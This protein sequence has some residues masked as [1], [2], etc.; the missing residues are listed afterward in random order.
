LRLSF[1]L[2]TEVRPDEFGLRS[3]PHFFSQAEYEAR[4]ENISA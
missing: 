3:Y 4:K 1:A 2:D